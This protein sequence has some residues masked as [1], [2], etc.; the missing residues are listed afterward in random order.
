MTPNTHS[1]TLLAAFFAVT[2][3]AAAINVT[4][5][6]PPGTSNHGDPNLICTPVSWID[7][8]TFF[9]GNYVAHAATVSSFMEKGNIAL[10]SMRS[11]RYCSLHTGSLEELP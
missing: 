7:I 10:S 11:R 2:V 1:Y 5:S 8:I 9:L 6:L 3:G 4:L